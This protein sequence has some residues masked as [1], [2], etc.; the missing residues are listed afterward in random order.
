[1]AFR[2]RLSLKISVLLISSVN[3]DKL[4][5]VAGLGFICRMGGCPTYLV[6]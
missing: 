1:M 4:F 5:T 2:V 6:G 3:L